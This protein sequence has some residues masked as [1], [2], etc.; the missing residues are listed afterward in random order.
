MC[1][2]H[3]DIVSSR[4][5]HRFVICFI[6]VEACCANSAPLFQGLWHPQQAK[7]LESF[8]AGR[9]P[10]VIFNIFMRECPPPAPRF[11]FASVVD[12]MIW[13]H[14]AHNQGTVHIDLNFPMSCK[15]DFSIAK[16]LR[17]QTI[18]RAFVGHNISS[19]LV[20]PCND[21]N[22]YC[23]L[24]FNECRACFVLHR[25]TSMYR[26]GS[27]MMMRDRVVNPTRHAHC[28]SASIRLRCHVPL[29]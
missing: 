26:N 2:A 20:S 5:S 24:K 4:T 21:L 9:N 3:S 28:S 15:H 14:I 22:G 11:P 18:S 12:G 10:R 23:V 6:S 19:D 16:L 8:P 7:P 13:P 29:I 27:W 17:L 1:L 25:L